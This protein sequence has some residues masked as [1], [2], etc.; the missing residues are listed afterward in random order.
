MFG[1]TVST[2][3]NITYNRSTSLPLKVAQ[4][5]ERVVI[6][7]KDGSV[8]WYNVGKAPVLADWYLTRDGAWF[9]F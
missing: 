2:R 8:S 9:E 7:N 6:L 4:N 1:Y 5:G 3:K